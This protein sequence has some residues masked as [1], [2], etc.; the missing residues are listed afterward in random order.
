MTSKDNLRQSV[1]QYEWEKRCISDAK[2]GSNKVHLFAKKPS[3]SLASSFLLLSN[4]AKGRWP[5]DV[6]YS[7]T[8]S[9]AR[10][11]W[12]SHSWGNVPKPTS[13]TTNIKIIKKIS[14]RANIFELWWR[15]AQVATGV[16]L[17]I[18]LWMEG[19]R[20]K[21]VTGCERINTIIIHII[22]SLYTCHCDSS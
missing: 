2:M 8:G 13:S 4:T 21:R 11:I 1:N 10:T 20:V 14:F 19:H 15:W 9:R 22:I 5:S 18:W 16:H 6:K 7:C 3:L 12:T 17:C